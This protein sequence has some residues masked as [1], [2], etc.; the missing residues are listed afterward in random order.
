MSAHSLIET[1][2]VRSGLYP[3]MLARALDALRA[4]A[5]R[6]DAEDTP[7]TR[8]EEGGTLHEAYALTLRMARPANAER[9]VRAIVDQTYGTTLARALFSALYYGANTDVHNQLMDERIPFT[10]DR[11]PVKAILEQ[12]DSARRALDSI[13]EY[14]PEEASAPHPEALR[15]ESSRLYY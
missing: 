12:L 3:P 15:R 2:F 9:I 13:A 4:L 7:F 10:Q 6:I 8:P 1:A 11:I 5:V 14:G